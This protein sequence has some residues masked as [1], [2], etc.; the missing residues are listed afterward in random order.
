MRRALAIGILVSA[1]LTACGNPAAK[2]AGESCVSSSEC[3]P[4]LLCDTALHVCAGQSSIDAASSADAPKADARKA[5]APKADA[6]MLDAF[7]P[8]DAPADAPTD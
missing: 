5:D 3:G 7:V 4:G 1:W 8:K 6:R 2:K